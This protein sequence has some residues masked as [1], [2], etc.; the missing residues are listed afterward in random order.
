MRPA[1]G[2]CAGAAVAPRRPVR[3]VASPVGAGALLLVAPAPANAA[4]P[5]AA[6]TAVQ[7]PADTHLSE[8]M[9]FEATFDMQPFAS[10]SALCLGVSFRD[11]LLDPGTADE[12]HLKR[13]QPHRRVRVSVAGRVRHAAGQ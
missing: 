12:I 10:I 8:G 1:R 6:S 4:D 5:I 13:G 11:D 2:G 9:A 3:A 7:L